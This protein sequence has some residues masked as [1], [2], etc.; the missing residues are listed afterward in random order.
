MDFVGF[1]LPHVPSRF[2]GEMEE[3]KKVREEK[4]KIFLY[5]T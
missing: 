5:I 2:D 3:N 1:E 4:L